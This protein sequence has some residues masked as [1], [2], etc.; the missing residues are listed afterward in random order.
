MIELGK[1]LVSTFEEDAQTKNTKE[2]FIKLLKISCNPLILLSQLQPN[3]VSDHSEEV[4]LAA[5]DLESSSQ[6][7]DIVLDNSGYELFTDLCL[8]DFLIANKMAQKIRIYVKTIPWF[9]SDV[10]TPDFDWTLKEL[11]KSKDANLKLLAA[12]WYKYVA[13]GA[14]DIIENEFFTL[15]IDYSFCGKR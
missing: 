15:P 5:S 4:W 13:C 1:Y 14:W 6:I 7:I 12:R 3:I 10:T 9:V 11:N 2:E 8:A